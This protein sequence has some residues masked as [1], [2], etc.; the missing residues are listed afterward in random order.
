LCSNLGMDTNAALH[1]AAR[2]S[3]LRVAV[4]VVCRL[5]GVTQATVARDIGV[6]A[7]FLSNYVH[8]RRDLPP[9]ILAKL[10]LRLGL[11]PSEPAPPDTC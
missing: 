9:P 3:D 8:G 4:S 6:S 11:G 2:N 5:L 10:R 7:P 1:E